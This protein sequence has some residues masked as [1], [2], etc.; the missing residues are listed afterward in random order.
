MHKKSLEA[1]AHL[2]NG[3]IDKESNDDDRSVDACSPDISTSTNDNSTGD[4]LCV[5]QYDDLH[6]VNSIN[7]HNTRQN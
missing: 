1:A 7:N 4:K 6:Y 3:E 2:E 5:Y